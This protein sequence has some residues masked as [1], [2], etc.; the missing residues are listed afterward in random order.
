MSEVTRRDLLR[1]AIRA[2]IEK[3][4]LLKESGISLTEKTEEEGWS[5]IHSALLSPYLKVPPESLRFLISS[6]VDATSADIYGNT[7]LH[8]AVRSSDLESSKI[9][10]E[11]GSSVNLPNR[12]GVTPLHQAL[13]RKPINFSLVEYLL[14]VGGDQNHRLSSGSTIRNYVAVISHGENASLKSLFERYGDGA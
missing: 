5:L 10:V 6:G 7:P 4:T 2:E 1:A 14:S 13:L 12:D 9:L 11:S 3:L 8:Y